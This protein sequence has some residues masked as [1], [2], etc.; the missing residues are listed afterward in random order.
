MT[1]TLLTSRDG[2]HVHVARHVVDIDIDTDTPRNKI[3]WYSICH[4]QCVTPVLFSDRGLQRRRLRPKGGQ[5]GRGSAPGRSGICRSRESCRYTGEIRQS[6]FLV[7]QHDNRDPCVLRE[8]TML[9][10]LV[11]GRL[12]YR[13]LSTPLWH[14]DQG[15]SSSLLIVPD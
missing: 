9:R 10:S 11:R 3:V 5:S 1:L 13:R 14:D 8:S 2:G 6:M 15:S 7:R 12:Q 4:T